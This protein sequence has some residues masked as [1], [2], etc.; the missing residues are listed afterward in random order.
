M[1]ITANDFLYGNDRKL[2]TEYIVIEENC[3]K[4]FSDILRQNGI[5]GVIA[6]LFD[7]NTLRAEGMVVPDIDQLI[8]LNVDNLH[9][10][11][12]A[13][14]TTL[15]QLRDDVTVIAAFGSGTITDIAR[16][17]AKLKNL[18]L[19]SCPT[20]ASVDG[21]C[22]SVCAMTFN[23]IKVTLPAVAPK[24]VIADLAVIKNASDRLIKSG[25]GDI[26]GKYVS[27]ADWKISS[28]ITGEYYCENTVKLVKEALTAVTDLIRNDDLFDA[29]FACGKGYVENQA[30]F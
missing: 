4:N 7:T 21:F 1:L 18:I 27:L 3:L 8:V 16:Y 14:E 5:D 22:S 6:G 20:A 15:S 24:T 13:V 23:G 25:L 2:E 19:V 29:A 30:E 28:S 17:C 10:D 9:A 11:E 26:L 12:K